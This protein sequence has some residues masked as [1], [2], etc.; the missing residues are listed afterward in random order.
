MNVV[1]WVWLNFGPC[2][3]LKF[4]LKYFELILFNGPF[5]SCPNKIHPSKIYPNVPYIWA[6][7]I[8]L[9]LISAKFYLLS[10]VLNVKNYQNC[11]NR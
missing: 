2:H 9:V 4:V 5:T 6:E 8:C 1:I 7:W 10:N 3:Y 11:H